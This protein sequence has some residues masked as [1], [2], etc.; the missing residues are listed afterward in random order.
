MEVVYYKCFLCTKEFK[1]EKT[2]FAHIKFNHFIR[3]NTIEMKCLVTG[4][5]CTNSYS[6]YASLKSHL[7]RCPGKKAKNQTVALDSIESEN[8]AKDKSKL[9]NE[10]SVTDEKITSNRIENFENYFTFDGFIPEDNLAEHNQSI[11]EN[12]ES[13]SHVE[14][15]QSNKFFEET[16]DNFLSSLTHQISNLKMTY[17]QTTAIYKLCLQFAKKYS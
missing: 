8:D 17:D 3:D 4:N 5:S 10:K 6:S 12:L 14:C 1:D 7:K 15:G 16:V 13:T 11:S 9:N 2:I